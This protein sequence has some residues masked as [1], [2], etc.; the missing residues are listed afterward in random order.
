LYIDIQF[1]LRQ[2]RLSVEVKR[3]RGAE[4]GVPME[5]VKT[6]DER[7]QTVHSTVLGLAAKRFELDTIVPLV[8]VD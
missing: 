6:F 8:S 7:P 3:W 5:R 4:A 1:E 2:Y